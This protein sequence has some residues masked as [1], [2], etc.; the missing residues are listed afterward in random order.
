MYDMD[1]IFCMSL[2]RAYVCHNSGSV[3]GRYLYVER[4][5]LPDYYWH[6]VIELPYYV[7]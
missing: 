5:L 3:D 6:G 2:W 4:I 7:D 1:G